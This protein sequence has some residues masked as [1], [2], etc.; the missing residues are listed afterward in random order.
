V[1]P[2]SAA[3]D[4]AGATVDEDDR[5]DEAV[6]VAE[7][8]KQQEERTQPV[9]FTEQRPKDVGIGKASC[10]FKGT[11]KIKIKMVEGDHVV[12]CFE[13]AVPTHGMDALVNTLRKVGSFL[14]SCK[15]CSKIL[16]GTAPLHDQYGR[17]R[18]RIL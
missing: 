4:T 6:L 17:F 16:T 2:G 12:L 18:W 13:P 14:T 3:T 5:D 9:L 8:Q 7:Q 15:V 10:V 11:L 1:A